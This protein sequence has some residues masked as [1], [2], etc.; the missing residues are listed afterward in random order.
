MKLN[1]RYDGSTDPFQGDRVLRLR[2]IP[3]GA[4][5]RGATA[6]ITPVQSDPGDPQDTEPFTER[7]SFTG[8]VG[9]WGAT[10]SKA[11]ESWVEVDFHARRTLAS[12][13]GTNL[14]DAT[15]QVDFGGAYV[16]INSAGGIKTSSDSNPFEL[17]LNTNQPLPGLTVNKIK[18]TNS[19]AA[20]TPG[21]GPDVAV[22]TIRSVP[23]NLTLRF[24]EA[25]TF[26]TRVGE[27]T[28]PEKTPDFALA[29]Q[30][31][32]TDA[33]P[34]NG[35]F[36]VPLIIHTDSIARLRIDLEVEFV[37]EESALG[38]LNTVALPFDF[39]GA[40]NVETKA[41][42][43]ALPMNARLSPRA[44][45][46]RIIGAFAETRIAYDPMEKVTTQTGSPAGSV[47][48]LAP[49]DKV[50]IAPGM[51]QAQPVSFDS[52][53]SAVAIDLLLEVKETARLQL[54]LREDLDGKPG[55]ISLLPK[56]IA[57]DVPGPVGLEDAAR[58]SAAPKWRSVALPAEFKFKA[59]ETQTP[60]RYWIIAQSLENQAL[61][62]VAAA[63]DAPNLKEAIGM[64]RST[65]DGLAW[66]ETAAPQV[67]GALTAFFRLRRRPDRFEMPI[68]LQ[69]GQGDEAVRVS[70]D[71]F[72][73]TGNV[74]FAL[75]FDD[76]NRGLEEHLRKRAPIC[77]QVEHILNGDFEQWIVDNASSNSESQFVV[78]VGQPVE[79]NLSAGSVMRFSL[80][81][82][83]SNGQPKAQLAA[84]G[85]RPNNQSP[86]LFDSVE[87]ALS[88][89]TPV[90]ASCAYDF[91]FQA[92][93]TDTD[94]VAEIFWRGSSCQA[95]EADPARI[96]IKVFPQINTNQIEP[97]ALLSI[98]SSIFSP[99]SAAFVINSLQ[100][101]RARVTAPAGAEQ[102]EIR[103]SVPEGVIAFIDNVSLM[104]TAETIANGDFR[105]I[106]KNQITNWMVLSGSSNG[107]SLVRP[108]KFDNSGNPAPF[109]IAQS[110]A[111]KPDQFFTLSVVK[112]ETQPS[113]QGALPG[114]ELRWLNDGGVEIG[115]PVALELDQASF[116]ALLASGVS[117]P[118]A[119]QAEIHIIVP[120]GASQEIENL[121]LSF[122]TRT[123]I[124][125]TFVA[126]APGELSVADWQIAYEEAPVT[127]PPIPPRGLC[128]PTP[129]GQIPGETGA[130]QGF[131]KCCDSQRPMADAV[132]MRTANNA[133]ALV[134]RCANCSDDMISFSGIFSP[135]APRLLA[136][137]TIPPQ[138][139]II[140]AEPAKPAPAP[141]DVSVPQPS[142][143][144]ERIESP[145]ITAVKGIGEKMAGRLASIGIGSLEDLAEATPERITEVKGISED[146]AARFIAEARELLR[147]HR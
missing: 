140:A 69:I 80:P 29:L 91:S 65:E 45:R 44:S 127:R 115:A 147:S 28:A 84:L 16:E 53:I 137:A 108:I 135:G 126:Q 9:Q 57:F 5:I 35:F 102:A 120:P 81:V 131:C 46:A 1:D 78:V 47:Q 61:W 114:V 14:V 113:A 124:P 76:V 105:Q 73:P 30:A 59:S 133:P 74:D 139:L 13:S 77:N 56:P 25:P 88:Q 19:L 79:W 117:P 55:R 94:A 144:P 17:T 146:Q 32:L 85:P 136:R 2:R 21:S 121:S 10:K 125:V 67:A 93:A 23:T 82:N 18:I 26:W 27:M 104:S 70:L 141:A 68:A 24:G 110:I 15:L 132:P 51:A 87:S 34:E 99:T 4:R 142:P 101:H 12:V 42:E 89:V 112:R 109:E 100:L 6:T 38:G 50:P 129:P 145:P 8:A 33:E 60:R 97:G 90:I 66:R 63:K 111:V 20:P 11:G 39:S 37:V 143:Q 71:R 119:T 95:V 83:Q 62:S 98:P 48:S 138:P 64:Q 54:D 86:K 22:V 118:D 130:G 107:I 92:I 116:G 123:L 7:V 43:L 134:G 41:L 72:A 31:F 128:A 96:P 40:P 75:N 103:F 49:A 122:P 3:A 36:D 52:E 58:A 106:D